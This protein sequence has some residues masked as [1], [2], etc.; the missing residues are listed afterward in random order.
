MYVDV[1]TLTEHINVWY[2]TCCRR[3]H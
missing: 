2:H 1:M 3:T